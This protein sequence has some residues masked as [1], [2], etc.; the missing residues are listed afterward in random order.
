[1]TAAG[2]KTC[3][4]CKKA[5]P[6]EFFTKS[7][8]YRDGRMG[9]C[10]PCRGAKWR[11]H[12]RAHPEKRPK[13]SKP[14]P[15]QSRASHIKRRYGLTLAEEANLKEKQ[16]GCCAICGEREPLN[17]DHCHAT[18]AVRGLLCNRCNLG[19]GAVGDNLNGIMRFVSYLEKHEKNKAAAEATQP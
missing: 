5:L 18:G 4:A 6:I 3:S 12:L 17:I 10:T 9:Q 11:E 8:G 1:M 19:L 15:A 16:G 14:T 7:K 13:S 2:I